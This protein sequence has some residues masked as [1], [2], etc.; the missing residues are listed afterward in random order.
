VNNKVLRPKDKVKTDDHIKIAATI[1]P[2]MSW[3]PQD[4]ELDIVYEDD[5]LLVLN[6]QAGLVVHPAAGLPDSTLLNALVHHCPELAKV[7]RAGIVHRIDK[8]TTGLLVVAKTLPAH[9]YLVQ[10]LQERNIKR[11][12][13]AIVWGQFTAGGTIDEPIGRHPRARV[14]MAVVPSGKKAITHYRI[15]ERFPALTHIRV[16]L[17]TGRTHQ[18]RVHMAHINHPIVGDPVYGGRTR[19]P[20]GASPELID[21]LKQF[22][23]QAL[24]AKHLALVHPR[25]GNL[26]EWDIELPN[27]MKH[28]LDLLR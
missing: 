23:R 11:E 7:P 3:K 16:I 14:K 27:D 28:L 19:L 10:E 21:E 1:E 15:L 2:E 24:H 13:E 9:N 22:K 6:K 4:I 17:E 25:T 18:I 12:Y 8:D 20:K 26:I 5:D